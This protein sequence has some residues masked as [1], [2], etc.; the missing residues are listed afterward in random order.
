ME[1]AAGGRSGRDFPLEAYAAL[2]PSLA[3]PPFPGAKRPTANQKGDTDNDECTAAT[4]HRPRRPVVLHGVSSRACHQVDIAGS[5]CDGSIAGES[6][7]RGS[8]DRE[9]PQSGGRVL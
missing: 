6:Q 9:I 5:A 2:H 8:K 3:S 4:C 1:A 7:R